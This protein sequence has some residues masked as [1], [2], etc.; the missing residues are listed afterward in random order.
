M[1]NKQITIDELVKE[2]PK[3]QFDY[4]KKISET[5]NS[6][7]NAIYQLNIQEILRKKFPQ[8]QINTNMQAES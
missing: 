5:N 8:V 3:F 4:I 1:P 7:A 6:L 2:I